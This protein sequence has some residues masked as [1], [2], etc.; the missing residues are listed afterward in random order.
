MSDP[1]EL[2]PHRYQQHWCRTCGQSFPEK[3]EN[4]A[5]P[6]AL[7]W[8]HRIREHEES[9]EQY[10]SCSRYCD[11]RAQSEEQRSGKRLYGAHVPHTAPPLG[12]R[13]EDVMKH[14][15]E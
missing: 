3:D 11:N 14:E 6:H 15:D 13:Y 7:V 4:G 2:I 10:V 12:R 5:S 8:V 9:M 1:M